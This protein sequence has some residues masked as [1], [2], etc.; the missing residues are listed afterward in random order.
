[1][2]LGMAGRLVRRLVVATVAAL[3]V[4][5]GGG[6]A[7]RSQTAP[8]VVLTTYERPRLVDFFGGAFFRDAVVS[9]NGR[10]L[11]TVKYVGT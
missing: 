5:L 6:Q 2:G 1:M 7:A 9:P 3:A 10:V 4:G 11:A 8:D